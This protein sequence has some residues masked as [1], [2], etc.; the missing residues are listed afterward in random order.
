MSDVSC[1][2]LRTYQVDGFSRR[3]QPCAVGSHGCVSEYVCSM[4]NCKLEG[5]SSLRQRFEAQETSRVG[6]IIIVFLDD[7]VER[8]DHPSLQTSTSSRYV[9]GEHKSFVRS[10]SRSTRC[11]SMSFVLVPVEANAPLSLLPKGMVRL[12]PPSSLSR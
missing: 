9:R 7:C 1:V 6:R 10:M 5:S 2:S 3:V 8:A 4:T 11:T 12:H